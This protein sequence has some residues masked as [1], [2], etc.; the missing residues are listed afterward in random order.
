MV[1]HKPGNASDPDVAAGSGTTYTFDPDGTPLA[2][3]SGLQNTTDVC[4]DSVSQTVVQIGWRQTNAFDGTKTYPVQI[5]F[6]RGRDF[7]GNIKWTDYNWPSN[8][9]DPNFLNRYTNNMADTRGM[10]CSIGR[11]GKLYAAFECAG[12]N[13]IFRYSPHDLTVSVPVAGGDTFHSFSNTRSEHKTFFAAYDPATGDYLRG[14]GLINRLTDGS[15]STIRVQGAE[16]RADESGRVY[17]GG[18]S[19]SGLPIPGSPKYMAKTGQVAFNPPVGSYTGGAWF[20]VLSADFKKRLYTTR[21]STGGRTVAV[22]GRE[23]G[24]APRGAWG[25]NTASPLHTAEPVQIASAGLGEGFLAV[26]VDGL[27]YDS[28]AAWRSSRFTAAQ[29][30]NPAASGD[31]A[32]ADGD[33]RSTLM[34]YYA[35]TNPLVPEPS[36]TAPSVENGLLTFRFR[37]AKAAPALTGAIASSPDLS[38]WELADADVRAIKDI[39]DAFLM[40]A[41]VPAEGKDRLFLRLG[42]SPSPR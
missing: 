27:D 28:V 30:A 21:L 31:A 23:L 24:G 42:L 37:R 36:E 13:H 25:G 12:G 6:I 1:A 41:G 34:E 16:I 17:I 26:L 20:M 11:D 38:A 32:D 14:Q 15:G 5:A 9:S 2:T 35:G 39:G 18:T 8:S 29:L 10:R 22:D 4:I 7:L 40:E 19:A 33:G 3:F